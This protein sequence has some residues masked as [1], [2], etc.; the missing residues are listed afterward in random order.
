MYR[1]TLPPGVF[2]PD[3]V[4]TL[5]VHAQFR[6]SQSSIRQSHRYLHWSRP[7]HFR[8]SVWARARRRTC[9]FQRLTS[10]R[11]CYLGERTAR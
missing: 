5:F 2:L 1:Y 9:Y 4:H 8:T 3:T 11:G 7:A 6:W 10:R